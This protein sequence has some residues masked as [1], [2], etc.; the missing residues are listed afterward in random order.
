M[1][2]PTIEFIQSQIPE[3]TIFTL[4]AY[5]PDGC[6]T[7]VYYSSS[8]QMEVMSCYTIEQLVYGHVVVMMREDNN[9]V[10]PQWEFTVLIN[11]REQSLDYE[12]DIDDLIIFRDNLQEWIK[13]GV[14][15][16]TQEKLQREKLKEAERY[17]KAEE[18]RQINLKY[19][20]LER[21]KLYRRLKKEFEP[22][23]SVQ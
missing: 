2:F 19:E 1:T 10:E 7:S 6:E 5:R 9:D 14:K 3:K 22:K 15:I 18:Q 20:K 12:E 4:I 16:F 21:E 23:E 17:R 8:S 11:G 13:D